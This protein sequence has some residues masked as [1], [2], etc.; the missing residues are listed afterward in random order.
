[1]L[2]RM[3]R[4]LSQFRVPAKRALVLAGGGVV[5]GMYEVG[6]LAALD[7]ALPGFRANAFDLY[8]GSS[9]GAVVTAL[10]ANQVHPLDLYQILDEERDDPL[11]FHRG[12]VYHKGSFSIAAKNFFQLVWAV[13]K[14]AVTKFRLE[15]PDILARSDSDMPA[16]F[17]SLGPL[18]AYVREAFA[19]K[20]LSNSFNDCPRRLLI[21]AIDLDRAERTVFGAGPFIDTPISQAISASSA[22]PGFFEPFRIDGRDY[23]DGDVG[24]TGHADLAVEWGA[25]VVVV[26][27]PAVPLR[28]GSPYEPEVRRRGMYAIMEQAGNITSIR[29]L[30]LGLAELRLRRPEVEFHLIQPDYRPSPLIG[31]SMG[32]EASRAALRFGYSS[33][34]EWLGT[35]D[36]APLR[37]RFATAPAHGLAVRSLSLLG[38]VKKPG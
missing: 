17:F 20:G 11:N 15:W 28:V 3:L 30:E 4:R 35:R 31:P 37:E 7:E 29:I 21:P 14:K 19:A 22:I 23:V 26:I 10:M 8:V 36:A 32:F 38:R 25:T 33:V 12:S 16:G 24:H 1:V 6:A 27:N 18:E 9:A 5:G 13:G 2:N 34:K